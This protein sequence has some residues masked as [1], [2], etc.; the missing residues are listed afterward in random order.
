[1]ANET[2]HSP[3]DAGHSGASQTTKGAATVV[4][5][6]PAESEHFPYFAGPHKPL[7]SMEESL[8]LPPQIDRTFHAWLGKLTIGMSPASIILAYQ[9]WLLHLASY[10]AKQH[11]LGLSAAA[12]MESFLHYLSYRLAGQPC[13]ACVEVEDTDNRFKDEAWNKLPFAMYAQGFLL[14]QDWWREATTN[15]HGVSQHHA[16]IVSFMTR[17][18]LDMISPA[19]FL[20]TNPEVLEATA[21][22]GG[23]NLLRGAGNAVEDM[24][25]FMENRLPRGTESFELGEDLA[26]CKGK[27]VYR[28][29]LFELIQYEPATDKVHP[30]PVLIIPAW[31][32]KYY[33]LDLSP[34]NSMVRYLLE[35]GH[36]VFIMSWKNP[37][38]DD[39]DLGLD[40]YLQQ[41]V[42]QAMDA[43]STICTNQPI[44]G[45]GYCIG[46]TL[47][48]MAAAYMAKRGD[49]RLKTL[50]LFTTQVDFEEAGELMMFVDESQ[51]AYL[52]DLMWEQGYLEKWQLSGAFNML[53]PKDLIWSRVVREYLLGKD[54]PSFDLLA[55]NADATRLP[56]AMHS[57]YLRKLYLN[58]DLAEHRYRVGDTPIHLEEIKQPVFAVATQK[59]HIA[60]WKSV[61]KLHTLLETDLTFV[62]TSGGHNAGIVSEP[63]HPRRYYQTTHSH[64]GN[65]YRSPEQWMAKAEQK[66]G[67]WWPQWQGWL[68]DQ[69]GDKTTPPKLGAASKGYKPLEDA[70][71]TYVF[72]R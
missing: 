7:G 22:Q 19:N 17:Q 39:A 43:V 32:M 71:G 56:Y 6:R 63:G 4:P 40:D 9:D 69:S 61:F 60:P 2:T 31:I 38:K 59:D 62:L 21:D 50:S 57:E 12:H 55:W 37:T 42:M 30:E 48:S 14:M 44:H 58:N 52:E 5:L 65:G 72:V 8:R 13:D 41:G 49:E 27:V 18:W 1:M 25:R 53:R 66:D 28:N 20:P 33:I 11:E 15:I 47:L 67:S 64:A 68:A 54:A 46:G 23:M 70:P 10:P 45:V 29:Q 34:H 35:Q 16:D 36:T 26:T 24:Q 51:L 3:N